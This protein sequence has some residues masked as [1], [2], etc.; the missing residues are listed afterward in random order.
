[1]CVN[2][3]DKK[4]QHAR[5]YFTPACMCVNFTT[6]VHK[7]NRKEM[8]IMEFEFDELTE[9]EIK[10]LLDKKNYLLNI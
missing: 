9:L 3:S 7:I 4:T 10:D 8:I 1:M 5:V 2:R 6:L